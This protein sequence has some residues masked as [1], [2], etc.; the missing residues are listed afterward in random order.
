[1]HRFVPLI[2]LLATPT[3][4]GASRVD[5]ADSLVETRAEGTVDWRMGVL[6]TEA[7][8]AADL[9]MPSAAIARAG[10]ER[11][12]RAA[13]RTR[14]VALLQGLSAGPDRR[15]EPAAI[16]RAVSRATVTDVD[17]QSN[18]GVVLRMR[19]NFGDWAV[20][21]ATAMPSATQAG[22][23]PASVAPAPARELS[24]LLPEARLQATPT[25]LV[26]GRPLAV[27]AA[28]YR[29][30][31]SL[32]AGMPTVAAHADRAGRIVLDGRLPTGELGEP[33]MVIYFQHLS[34]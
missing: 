32:P 16:D 8:A 22:P 9:R 7:G 24:I 23:V 1:M 21:P 18:G 28:R 19:C 13:A 30:A 29:P 34:K 3:A 15:L 4:A 27:R 2:L 14:M 33:A 10:S 31:V 5:G 11:H 17:Y 6:T 12:A 26:A 25:V 20:A